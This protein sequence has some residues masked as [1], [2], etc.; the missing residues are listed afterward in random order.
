MIRTF[1][2]ALMTITLNT[3]SVSANPDIW[4]IE[5]WSQ[6]DFSKSSVDFDTILSGGPPKD[7]IPSIDQ[8]KFWLAKDI[9]GL[10]AD[11]PII[12]LTVNGET[13]AY[14][15]RILTWHEIINDVI[16]GVPVAVTYCPLCNAAVVFERMVDGKP[17][18]FGVSGKLRY[19][20]MIMYDRNSESWWQQFTGEAIIGAA[21]GTKLKILPSRTQSW[22]QFARKFPDS[23]V[24]VPNNVHTRQYGVNPYVKYDSALKPFLFTGEFPDDIAPMTYVVAVQ[25]ID[26]PFVVTLAK[27]REEK[28]LIR[29][30]VKLSWVEGTRSALDDRQIAKGRQIGNVSAKIG[31]QDVAYDLTFAF[32]THAFLPNIPIEQ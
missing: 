21:L 8:P 14:P 32:V 13:K 19:S 25:D 9:E 24:L 31:D 22:S 7:G 15:I 26:E 17:T 11:E 28:Q 18:E 10:E 2:L 27:V 29:N 6:T 1:I 12:G 30:G 4:K 5:G 16:G 23:Q 20:D 3:I